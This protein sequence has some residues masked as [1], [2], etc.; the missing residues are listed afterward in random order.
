MVIVLA[1]FI[2]TPAHGEITKGPYL[3]KAGKRN[4]TIMWETEISD[5]DEDLLENEYWLEYG[6]TASLGKKITSTPVPF[7]FQPGAKKGLPLKKVYIYEVTLKDLN[8]GT[9]YYYRVLSYE[10]SSPARIFDTFPEK[11][12]PFRFAVYG[13]S[14]SN[15]DSNTEVHRR[16]ASGILSKNPTFIIHTGDFTECGAQ[17]WL[18][19][20]EVF[21]PLKNLIDHIPFWPAP[22]NHEADKEEY[23]KLFSLPSNELWY[24]FDYGNAHFVSLDSTHETKDTNDRMYQWA[25]EDLKGSQAQWKFVFF[26]YPCYDYSGSIT[27]W[28]RKFYVSLFEKCGVDFTFSGHTHNYERFHPLKHFSRKDVSP[29]THVVAAGG[30]AELYTSR[31]SPFTAKNA[32]RHHYCIVEIAGNHLVMTVYDIKG[33][34]IDKMELEK[35]GRNQPADYL[36]QARPS[37]NIEFETS[38]LSY[39][40][41]F[42]LTTLPVEGEPTEISLKAS[43]LYSDTPLK[44]RL[45]LVD[46]A[47]ENWTCKPQVYEG[48]IGPGDFLDVKFTVTPKVQ[49]KVP[50]G[51]SY[52][53]PALQ[54][55]C[56]YTSEYGQREFKLLPVQVDLRAIKKATGNS[57]G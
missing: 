54:F 41:G 55:R 8:P 20:P 4:I 50:A 45:G 33:K 28:G 22:G 11:E 39:I 9:R 15:W 36:G 3:Q 49:V 16:I 52:L 18:W 1:C 24:S 19:G 13:D 29:V 2:L 30:G 6:T 5:E 12:T 26:H 42:R 25:M 46:E 27:T 38:L 31:S 47:H 32:R 51:T 34:I 40:N 37:E 48:E 57:G 35:K 44:L 17:Y 7:E 56:K 23:L 53:N 21:G 10:D 43:N 14:R